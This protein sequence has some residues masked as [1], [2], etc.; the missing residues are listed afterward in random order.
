MRRPNRPRV[1]ASAVLLLPG[2]AF[3]LFVLA[4]LGALVYRAVEGGQLDENL[5]EGFVIDALRLSL[6]TAT[7]TLAVVLLFGTPLAYL[8]AR[9]S[10][11]GKRLV[12][13]LV[14]LPLVLP[15]VVGGVTLLLAFGRRGLIGQWL[16][17][18]LPDSL[19]LAVAP[20]ATI[21]IPSWKNTLRTMPGVAP[22]LMSVRMSCFFSIIIIV[23]EAM[24]LNAPIRPMKAPVAS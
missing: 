24:M 23:S 19:L 18:L 16:E 4:P 5:R 20:T 13:T 8:L 17:F 15:P 1:E 11:P 2:V 12:D 10:F 7:F 3:A 6:V 9:A 22:M 21:N 14:D